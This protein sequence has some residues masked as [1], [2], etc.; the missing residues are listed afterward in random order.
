MGCSKYT[1]SNERY[2]ISRENLWAHR[3][4][5]VH[6]TFV[7]RRFHPLWSGSLLGNIPDLPS[8]GCGLERFC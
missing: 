4:I 6:R 2:I 5:Q 3:T 8:D 7:A 1:G